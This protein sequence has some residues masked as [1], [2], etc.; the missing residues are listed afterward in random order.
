MVQCG[1]DAKKKYSH[2]KLVYSVFIKHK[3]DESTSEKVVPLGIRVDPEALCQLLPIQ[4]DYTTNSRTG[5]GGSTSSLGGGKAVLNSKSDPYYTVPR[6]ISLYDQANN[7]LEKGVS[8]YLLKSGEDPLK[9]SSQVPKNLQAQNYNKPA[10]NL[11]GA[12]DNYSYSYV[13]QNSI[14]M[15]VQ[16][17]IRKYTNLN[18][19]G[20][21]IPV[22]SQRFEMIPKFDL[23][24]KI[25]HDDTSLENFFLENDLRFNERKIIGIANPDMW[26]F[27]SYYKM[28]DAG[29]TYKRKNP[30]FGYNHAPNYTQETA[31]SELNSD[32][33]MI[34][35]LY[36]YT[37]H[38][39]FIK[40]LAAKFIK[41]VLRTKNFIGVH[42][43][44]NA[45]DYLIGKPKDDELEEF[46]KFLFDESLNSTDHRL[47]KARHGLSADIIREIYKSMEDPIYFLEMLIEHIESDKYL[48]L[49]ENENGYTL[50][51]ASPVSVAKKF[52][53]TL[54]KGYY[55][56]KTSNKT[57]KIFTGH[58]TKKFLTY[59]LQKK[60]NCKTLQNYFGEILSTFEKELMVNS[61]SFYR[62]R[63][64]NWSFNVQGQRFAFSDDVGSDLVYDRVIYDVFLKR[65][66][67][68][69]RSLGR[70][71]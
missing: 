64:S 7:L 61:K 3:S 49:P 67:R 59:Y 6:I 37:S 24:D 29:G 71:T 40:I 17:Y 48:N 21:F 2:K 69:K 43:R 23:K 50:V 63:P 1:L 20:L 4:S 53:N 33:K 70:R 31:A 14:K 52:E 39:K 35:N 56:S 54:Q 22:K 13:R 66:R 19:L 16:Q 9:N 27:K 5:T 60:H 46:R 65:A 38:P 58:D 41:G 18:A 15:F 62:T 44:F 11:L 45:N 57:Y 68:R 30:I 51:I 25:D 10:T 12:G 28:I 55:T 32:F 34:K 26:L 47:I 42:W 8:G 36:K